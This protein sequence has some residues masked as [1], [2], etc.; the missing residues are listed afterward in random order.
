LLSEHIFQGLTGERSVHLLDWPAPDELPADGELVRDM[1]CVRDVCSAAHSVRKAQ[2]LR[3]RLPLQTLTV[4]GPGASSLAPFLDL[5]TDEVNVK[6]VRLVDEVGAAAELV[7]TVN[8]K[9]AGPRLGG[10]VQQAIRAVKAGDWQRGPDD[11]VVAAGITLVP[12]EFD[13]RLT[14][15]DETTTRVVACVDGVVVLDTQATP[16]LEAEGAARD[17]VRLVQE[18]RRKE[19]LHVSDRIRL[20][21]DVHGHDDLARAVDAHRSWLMEQTL[22]VDL[23]LAPLSEGHRGELPD[24]RAVRIGITRAPR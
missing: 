24:G 17:V 14:P 8:P 3:A 20:T 16:E 11:T 19:G 6:E 23:E 22:A 5:I 13:L 9:A 15:A 1:D 10:S 7:L 12:G 18:A 4:A 21:L 2:G